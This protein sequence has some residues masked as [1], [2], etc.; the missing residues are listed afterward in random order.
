M[1]ER[2]NTKPSR[3]SSSETLLGFADTFRGSRSGGS[4]PRFDPQDLAY[5]QQQI[6]PK[7]DSAKQFLLKGID[8]IQT[9]LPKNVFFI[10]LS[11]SHPLVIF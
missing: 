9:F 8:I 1:R 7:D 4:S 3:R 11:S 6:S 10:L 2:E 5:L